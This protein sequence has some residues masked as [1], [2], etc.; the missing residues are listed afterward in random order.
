MALARQLPVEIISVD[1]A[2]VYRGM[3][4]GTAKPSAA[5]RAITIR[6][7]Q[8]LADW[9]EDGWHDPETTWLYRHA[10]LRGVAAGHFL[11]KV[12]RTN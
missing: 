1:S 12:A 2:L 3:D 7:K 8:A 4:I 10:M 9:P 6:L 5:D 11:R